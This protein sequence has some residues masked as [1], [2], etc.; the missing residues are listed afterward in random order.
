MTTLT[1][2][3]LFDK[4]CH[5]NPDKP[6]GS[7]T[8]MALTAFYVRTAAT[9]DVEMC[10]CKLHLHARWGIKALLECANTDQIS[11]PFHDYDTFFSYLTRNCPPSE[12]TYVS[13]ECSIDKKLLCA[14]ITGNWNALKTKLLNQAKV[15][16]TKLQNFSYVDIVNQKTGCVSKN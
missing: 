10:C 2:K 8:F 4:Y 3:Q 13:W 14:D 16:T 7:S 12:T 9:K 1:Y 5:E 15:N 6:V 11:L